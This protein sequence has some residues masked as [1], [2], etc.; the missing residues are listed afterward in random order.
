M[1]PKS[2]RLGSTTLSTLLALLSCSTAI[3]Y[4]CSLRRGGNRGKQWM[5]Q[6]LRSLPGRMAWLLL[7]G[8]L[9]ADVLLLVDVA[10]NFTAMQLNLLHNH[11]FS[12]R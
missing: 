10:W 12:G 9:E 7:M 8:H 4:L 6:T 1:D 3:V 5:V 2:L 11:D